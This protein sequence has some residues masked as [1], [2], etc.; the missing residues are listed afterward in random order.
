MSGLMMSAARVSHTSRNPARVYNASPVTTGIVVFSFTSLIEGMLSGGQGSSNQYG[1]NGSNSRAT[2]IAFIGASRRWT[3]INSSTL[4]PT[5]S[6][7]AATVRT[8]S[9]KASRGGYSV[10]GP[11]KGSNFN[12]LKPRSATTVAA[13]SP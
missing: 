6:R 7:T 3:S 1:F 10:H 12:A 13:I 2:R 4:G 9:S 8:A 5:A 11:G